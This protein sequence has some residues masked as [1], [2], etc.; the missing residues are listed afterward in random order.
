MLRSGLIEEELDLPSRHE[1]ITSVRRRLAQDP[2]WRDY[3]MGAL[4]ILEGG[5]FLRIHT[6]E[7]VHDFPF[8]IIFC[9]A[10]RTDLVMLEELILTAIA[11][12]RVL[13]RELI[14]RC[15]EVRD[16][17]CADKQVAMNTDILKD[18][19]GVYKSEHAITAVEVW[20]GNFG[21]DG[22]VEFHR[23][24]ISDFRATK[25]NGPAVE[26]IEGRCRRFPLEIGYC[27]PDQVL[28]HLEESKCIAR[29][30]YGSRWIVFLEDVT[31]PNAAT[32]K[33][34]SKGRCIKPLPGAE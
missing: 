10:F 27:R 32:P 25:I 33:H 7:E 11:W 30:P 29:F 3:S 2:V 16:P 18:M 13:N 8:K 28:W 22:Y 24:F 31:S 12:Q 9:Q 1:V 14:W 5:P 21:A 34:P 6:D 26:P 19:M 4:E 23:P 17:P 20:D 15:I